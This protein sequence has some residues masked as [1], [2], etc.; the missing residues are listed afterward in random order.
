MFQ[1]VSEVF[2][3]TWV[4]F[5]ALWVFV[6]GSVLNS[7]KHRSWFRQDHAEKLVSDQHLAGD[8]VRAHRVCVCV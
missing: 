4:A 7:L 2:S 8:P 6:V 5:V 1:V 3:G